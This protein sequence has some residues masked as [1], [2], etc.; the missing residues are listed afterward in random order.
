MAQRDY[1]IKDYAMIG[2]CETA[3]LINPDGGIDWLCVF[4]RSIPRLSLAP[5]WTENGQERIN[6]LMN[7]I[8]EFPLT[9]R[10]AL[11]LCPWAWGKMPTGR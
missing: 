5:S 9:G 6:L 2:N 11:G 3:A 7:T 10:K 4:L 1:A 8:V